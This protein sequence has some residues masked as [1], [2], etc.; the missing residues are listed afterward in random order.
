M[1]TIPFRALAATLLLAS[2]TLRADSLSLWYDQPAKDWLEALPVGNGALGGMVFG[3]VEKDRIQFNEQTLWTGDETK[4]GAYQPFGDLL[5]EFAPATA[6][7][8]RRELSLGDAVHRVTYTADNVKYRR[9]VFCSHPEKV[10]VIRL[11]ADK[12]GAISAKLSLEDMHKAVISAVGTLLKSSG[13]LENGLAY[14]AQVKVL[15]EGGQ[16]SADGNSVSVQGADSVTILLAAGT[17]FANSPEKNWR[18]EHPS[19]RLERSEEHTSE[20]QSRFGI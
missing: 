20:L 3:G 7:G 9:E 14:E 6:S 17:T 16:V 18:G 12:P 11:S 19:K 4:M 2:G 5:L 15:N 10:M 1:I 8:Y 13:K